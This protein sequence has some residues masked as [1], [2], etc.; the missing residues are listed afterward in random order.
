MVVSNPD[1]CHE[2]RVLHIWEIVAVFVAAVSGAIGARRAGMDFFGMFVL[3]LVT[4][5]GGGTLR[6]LLLG[7]LPPMVL[8]D[9]T[10][11]LLAVIATVV[12]F[13]GDRWWSKVKRLV[14]VVDALSIGLFMVIGIEIARSH[15]LDWWACMGMGVVTATFGGVLRDILRAEVP[16]IF[17]KEIYA[18]AC[19]AGGFLFFA[20]EGLGLDAVLC[21]L[22]TVLF[23]TTVRMLAIRYALHHSEG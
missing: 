20:L 17:R 7:D 8:K 9:P 19:V 5:V 14:S 23:V 4:G 3:A 2:C 21:K 15:H 18:S 12:S 11:L 13:S 16:L 22:G 10:Y 1:S 6:S